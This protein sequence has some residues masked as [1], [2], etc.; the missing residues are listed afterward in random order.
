MYNQNI[1]QLT[2]ITILLFCSVCLLFILM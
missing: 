1:H 2:D